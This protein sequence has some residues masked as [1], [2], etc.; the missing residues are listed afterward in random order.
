MEMTYAKMT[1]AISTAKIQ[2]LGKVLFLCFPKMK[3]QKCLI[4][5]RIGSVFTKPQKYN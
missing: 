1:I 2:I 5:F 4:I 3:S